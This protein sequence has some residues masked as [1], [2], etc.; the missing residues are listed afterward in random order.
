MSK[1]K[2]RPSR[3]GDEVCEP[4][5]EV[6]ETMEQTRESCTNWQPAQ[7]AG[8]LPTTFSAGGGQK[9]E[10]GASQRAEVKCQRGAPTCLTPFQAEWHEEKSPG[11]L[12]CF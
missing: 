2:D 5:P 7:L 12:G 4:Q 9:R 3:S 8:P 6:G 1:N 10:V 11:M